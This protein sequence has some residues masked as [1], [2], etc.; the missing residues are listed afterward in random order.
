MI[1]LLINAACG[2]ASITVLMLAIAQSPDVAITSKL[3]RHPS[4]NGTATTTKGVSALMFAAATCP[5]NVQLLL[6]DDNIKTTVNKKW[7]LI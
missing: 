5:V 4:I 2:S 6:N 3:L 1:Y 7:Y